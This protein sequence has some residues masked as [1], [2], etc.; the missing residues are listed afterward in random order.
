MDLLGELVGFA[1]ADNSKEQESG[2]ETP[3]K[4]D[5]TDDAGPETE[6][7]AIVKIFNN[8]I[9]FY[10]CSDKLTAPDLINRVQKVELES[11]IYHEV[12]N[13][14]SKPTISS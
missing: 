2:I 14:L 5:E 6:G 1:G 13:N 9:K 3:H 12:R 8:T 11:Y 7:N 4:G 10:S